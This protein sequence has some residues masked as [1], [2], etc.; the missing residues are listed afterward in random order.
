[1]TWKRRVLC[2][3]AT[4][5]MVGMGCEP[6]EQELETMRVGVIDPATPG[7]DEIREEEQEPLVETNSIGEEK[8]DVPADESLP[9]SAAIE[10]AEESEFDSDGP[11]EAPAGPPSGEATESEAEPLPSTPEPTEKEEEEPVSG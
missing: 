3:A 6:T 9:E 4:M 7:P 10:P 1:M 5:A 11:S 8:P 2:V